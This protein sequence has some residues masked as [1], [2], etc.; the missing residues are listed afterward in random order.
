MHT[1]IWKGQ[2]SWALRGL[3]QLICSY[4]VHFGHMELIEQKYINWLLKMCNI[5]V[6]SIIIWYFVPPMHTCLPLLI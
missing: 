6:V 2:G 1:V 3:A 4:V 5:E